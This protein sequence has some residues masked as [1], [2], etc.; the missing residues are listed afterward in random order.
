VKLCSFSF[1]S[2][3]PL[4]VPTSKGR[5]ALNPDRICRGFA[6]A[7]RVKD[8]VTRLFAIVDFLQSHG[9]TTTPEL[10]QALNVSERTVQRDLVRLQELDIAVES[11]PGRAGG[12]SLA[13]GSL[14]S[15]LRFTSDELLALGLG[16]KLIARM[17]DASLEKA[18]VRAFKRLEQVLTEHTKT[19]LEALTGALALKPPKTFERSKVESS[20]LLGLAEAVHKNQTL[21]L[22]YVSPKGE[23]SLRRV[24]PY[25]LARLYGNWYFVGYCHLRLGLRTFRVDRIRSFQ[26]SN[27]TFVKPANFDTY[28]ET[29]RSLNKAPTLQAVLCKIRLFTSIEEASQILPSVEALLEPDPKGVL[30]TAQVP[31]NY[32]KN[33]AFILLELPCQLEVVE[34]RK[35]K[36]A[37]LDIAQHASTLGKR[38]SNISKP[39]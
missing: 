9:H 35:L 21:E 1:S 16:V 26:L 31:S 19:Q 25:G 8:V 38:S 22:R 4:E 20:T 29:V 10:A 15:P 6:Y 37:F 7:N 28:S 12:I 24:D 39:R 5:I 23:E 34:S 17:G 3:S 36:K 11:S 33:F 2:L 18:S 30:L 13:P 14:L 27:C 32:L